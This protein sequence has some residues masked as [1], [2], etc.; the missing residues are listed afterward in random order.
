MKV[1]KKWWE[2][3]KEDLVFNIIMTSLMSIL[4]LLTIYLLIIFYIEV[5]NLYC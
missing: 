2:E 4:Y 5:M 1:I 3:F